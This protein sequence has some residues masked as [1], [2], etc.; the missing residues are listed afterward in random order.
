MKLMMIAL[1]AILA[2][3]MTSAYAA[4]VTVTP[5]SEIAPIGTMDVGETQ[6]SNGWS[7]VTNRMGWAKLSTFGPALYFSRNQEGNTPIVAGSP[8]VSS[9]QVLGRGTFYA[10]C[11][12]WAG[13][14]DAVGDRTPS[15]VW[16]GT[17][18][19][20]GTPLAGRTLG[21]ITEMSYYS[22][23]DKCPTRE[24]VGTETEWWAKPNWWFGPQ[25][26][27]QIQLNVYPPNNPVKIKAVW[28]RPWGS[29]SNYVGDDG[30]MEPG[31]KKGRWQKF[32]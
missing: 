5:V 15:T 4:V 10:T 28:Y 7:I 29:L 19:W 16:L 12:M 20:K 6:L 31:S 32:N 30:T 25:Q 3:T 1:L 2:L 18:T 21:S 23:V 22:F 17:S 9:P 24:D 14:S 8:D 27:I 13:A 11:D 26:P